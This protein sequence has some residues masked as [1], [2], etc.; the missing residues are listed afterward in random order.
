MLREIVI[1]TMATAAFSNFWDTIRGRPSTEGECVKTYAAGAGTELGVQLGA[2]YC[3]D[4]YGGADLTSEARSEH[5]CVLEG[6]PNTKNEIGLR[7]LVIE[8]RKG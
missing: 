1:A 4:L 6:L 7:T 5:W 2:R 8:C 3:R